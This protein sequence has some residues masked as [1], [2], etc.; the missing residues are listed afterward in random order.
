[1]KRSFGYIRD[2]LEIK[3]LILFIMRR[4]QEPTSPDELTELALHDD[5]ISYFDFMECVTELV[6]TEHLLYE[7]NEYSI[8]DKGARNGEI[9]EKSL[10]F[11]LRTHMEKAIFEYRSRKNR[12][13]MINTLHTINPDGNCKVTLS[14]SDGIGEILSM[15]MLAVNERQALA[16]EKGFRKNAEGIYNTLIET[17]LR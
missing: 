4:I 16:L 3:V 14:L 12:N 15:E 8:T 7:D 13:T 2:K 17:I 9:T 11:I 6:K 1:M 5:G 10:P